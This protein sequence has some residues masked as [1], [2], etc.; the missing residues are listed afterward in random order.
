MS[1]LLIVGLF[2]TGMFFDGIVFPALFGFRES[3]LTIV[4]I[5]TTLLYYGINLHGMVIG[6]ILSAAAEFYWGLRLGTLVLGFL[7]SAGML[8]LLNSF[9][10]IRSKIF[11]FFSG[12]IAIIVFWTVSLFVAKVL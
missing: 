3:F 8:S 11:M 9:L 7:A 2:L 10:N 6:V 4:F 12:V 1:R 5:I